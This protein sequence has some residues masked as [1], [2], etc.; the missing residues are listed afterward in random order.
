M[1]RKSGII[2]VLLVA[3]AILVTA[4]ASAA[5]ANKTTVPSTDGWIVTPLNPSASS[6]VST[7]ALSAMATNVY[8]I[9]QGQNNW[10]SF[11]VPSGSTGVTIDLN[12]G[13]SANSLQLTMYA[14]D[15][16][17]AGPFYDSADGRIDGRICISLSRNDEIIPSGTYY[18]KT[19]GYKVSGTED[20][21]I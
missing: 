1:L 10:K 7:S 15:G 11:Y 2:L 9:T 16:S 5:S 17:V 12:W 4:S 13:N 20:Y 6:M 3:V 21:T 18:D 19:Y 8:Y 14:S